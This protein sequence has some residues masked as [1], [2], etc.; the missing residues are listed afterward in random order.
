MYFNPQAELDGDWHSLRPLTTEGQEEEYEAISP[1]GIYGI[2]MKYNINSNWSI[3]GEF[4][5]RFLFHDY[6]DDISTTY[7]NR[8]TLRE[9]RGDIAATLS[10]RSTEVNPDGLSREGFQRGNS[11][12]ADNYLFIQVGISYTFNPIKC[13]VLH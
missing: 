8:E 13:P 6:L 10:D 5:N 9:N 11:E 7:T 2:G 12:I 4:G 1:L 3:N